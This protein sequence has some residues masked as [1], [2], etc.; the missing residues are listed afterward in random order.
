MRSLWNRAG[1]RRRLRSPAIRSRRAWSRAEVD[2]RLREI[3]RNIHGQCVR[4][5][6][7]GDGVD[8][9]KGANIAGF[10]KVANAMLAQGVL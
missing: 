3:M 10:R 6:E 4:W 5:G 9:V 2:N 8:Y 7:D 1:G